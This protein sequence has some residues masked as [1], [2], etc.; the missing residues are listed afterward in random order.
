MTL[1]CGLKL[2]HDGA[3]AVVE[4]TPDGVRLVAATEVEK[5]GNRLRHSPLADSGLVIEL[6]KAFNLSPHDID[7]WV[8]DGWYSDK[9]ATFG[10]GAATEPFQVSAMSGDGLVIAPYCQQDD[11]TPVLHRYSPPGVLTLDGLNVPYESYRHAEGHLASAYATTSADKTALVLVWDGHLYPQVYLVQPG[12]G[13]SFVGDLFRMRGSVFEEFCCN[14]PPF[15][16][17][18][19]LTFEESVM[20]KA[21]VPGKAMAYAGLASSAG[22]FAEQSVVADIKRQFELL[23]GAPHPEAQLFPSVARTDA[24]E[25]S[26][27]A[28]MQQAVGEILVEKLQPMA[29]LADTLCFAG[30]SAL[31]IKWNSALRSSGLFEEVWVPPFC[32]DSGSA[33][34]AA[35]ASLMNRNDFRPL[36]WSVYAGP[37]APESQLP[38]G[39]TVAQS[40]IEEL[41]ALLADGHPVVVI[42]GRAELGPRALGHRSILADPRFASM[43]AL[44]N[45][46]KGREPYRPVAPICLEEHA[47]A[48]FDPGVP[49][50]YM[51]FDH[52]VRTEWISR[53]PAIIH[54]DGTARL[55]TVKDGFA[56]DVLQEFYRR[57]GVP[58]L[59]NT[60]ANF[61]GSGFFPDAKSAMEWGKVIYV[62]ADGLIYRN[63]RQESGR[64]YA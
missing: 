47:A 58:V 30:G 50:P 5:H 7:R 35:T 48:I 24:D 3:L 12:K 59:C 11:T 31:N 21:G 55:Q 28:A 40:D 4:D 14:L 42:Q 45:R 29:H 1:I 60:S 25:A 62:W 64:R 18:D 57:T 53:L 16:P 61:N 10:G 39:W 56:Y 17:P 20:F 41:V 9:I 8:V 51:L 6:L 27:I 46:L 63:Y 22:A 36:Q 44:L 23:D 15:V 38:H 34:G 37:T 49:D 2:T 33:I 43:K 19:E 52:T 13:V 54:V 26:M 32:N